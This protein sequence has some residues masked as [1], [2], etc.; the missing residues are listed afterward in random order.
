MASLI[1]H[2]ML[3]DK[4]A[5]F[6]V[7]IHG[8]ENKACGDAGQMKWKKYGSRLSLKNYLTAR[9]LKIYGAQQIQ[10]ILQAEKRRAEENIHP[11]LYFKS[12]KL[13]FYSNTQRV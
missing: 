7:L 1:T 8:Y 11:L 2:S 10:T 4:F 3:K 5:K 12:K 6:K 9:F 13:Y